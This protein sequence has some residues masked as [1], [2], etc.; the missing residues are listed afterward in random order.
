[1]PE[2]PY[3]VKSGKNGTSSVAPAGN[4][5]HPIHDAFVKNPNCH[6][7]RSEG[8]LLKT[9][10]PEILPP[11]RSDEHGFPRIESGA[12]SSQVRNDGMGPDESGHRGYKPLPRAQSSAPL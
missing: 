3:A 9:S 5:C 2:N 4:F 8:S 7:E 1:L 12:G 6:P 10:F 11:S